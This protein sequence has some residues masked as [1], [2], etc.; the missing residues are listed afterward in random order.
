MKAETPQQWIENEAS[1][2]LSEFNPGQEM[3]YTTSMDRAYARS[4][5]TTRFLDAL[6]SQGLLKMPESLN[7]DDDLK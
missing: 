4:I 6:Y 7:K 1:K 3:F 2:V 5:A